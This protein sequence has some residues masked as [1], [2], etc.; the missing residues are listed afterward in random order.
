MR[1]RRSTLRIGR[2]MLAGAV[3]LALLAA[4]VS[5]P[6]IGT[7]VA[8]AVSVIRPIPTPA[9]P[10]RPTP[11]PEQSVAAGTARIVGQVLEART[12]TPVADAIVSLDPYG[13]TARTNADGNFEIGDLPVR[14]QC[15][16]LTISVSAA[17]FGRLRTIDNPLYP[18]VTRFQL[19]LE[20]ND[21]DHFI[22]APQG[23]LPSGTAFCSR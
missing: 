7:Y 21:A 2:A 11:I 23:G 15:Q 13:N 5:G 18:T 3:V 14:G 22:G 4:V 6:T 9:A 20:R 12:F 19:F 17:G 1:R 16:W 10:A 8:A